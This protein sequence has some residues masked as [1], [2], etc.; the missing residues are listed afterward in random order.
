M[1]RMADMPMPCGRGKYALYC[2]IREASGRDRSGSGDEGARPV[3]REIRKF[4]L[5]QQGD[6]G[7]V[8]RLARALRSVTFTW[9]DWC[10]MH[11]TVESPMLGHSSC[12]LKYHYAVLLC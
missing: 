4:N 8:Q 6:E 11:A 12:L 9:I 3:K 7:N 10:T 1:A 2:A 5:W